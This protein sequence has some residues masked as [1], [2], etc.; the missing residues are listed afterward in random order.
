MTKHKLSCVLRLWDGCMRKPAAADIRLYANGAPIRHRFKTGGF[1]VLSDLPDGFCDIC[2]RSPYYLSEHFSVVL[3]TSGDESI[4]SAT[5]IPSELHPCFAFCPAAEGFSAL[6][7]FYLL[8]G[9]FKLYAREDCQAGVDHIEFLGSRFEYFLP[10]KFLLGKNGE[11]EI[12]TLTA[13]ENNRFALRSPLKK[14]MT[15]FA[16]AAPLFP[17]RCDQNGAFRSVIPPDFRAKPSRGEIALT[18]I[19]EKNG[20]ILAERISVKA[21]GVTR[22]GHSLFSAEHSISPEPINTEE[23]GSRQKE[24]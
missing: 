14:S 10:S 11:S 21:S 9:A 8:R 7:R 3:P 19:A 16:E 12:V 17:V 20:E 13:A 6:P 5:L 22:L 18:L 2:V 23:S 4:L 15:R 24:D 1:F